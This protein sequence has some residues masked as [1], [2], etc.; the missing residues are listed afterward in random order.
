MAAILTLALIVFALWV[1]LHAALQ[2][3]A[4]SR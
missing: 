4:M 2:A 3:R 1:T